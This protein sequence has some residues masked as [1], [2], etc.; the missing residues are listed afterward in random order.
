MSDFDGVGYEHDVIYDDSPRFLETQARAETAEAEL[1]EVKERHWIYMKA[2]GDA[3]GENREKDKHGIVAKSD[4]TEIRR[5]KAE[6]AEAKAHNKAWQGDFATLATKRGEAEAERD[7]IAENL[8]L[9]ERHDQ[10]K[11]DGLEKA[12]KTLLDTWELAEGNRG[13]YSC[14]NPHDCRCPAILHDPPGECVC[15]R[16]DLEAAADRAKEVLGGGET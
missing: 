11:I 10:E 15:Y 9:L 16:E 1:A 12:L 14:H 5:L 2:I 6:L 4:A 8:A 13:C 3:I 7:S